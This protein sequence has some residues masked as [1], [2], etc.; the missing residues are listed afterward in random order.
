VVLL[1]P[2]PVSL[3]TDKATATHHPMKRSMT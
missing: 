1:I 2:A 3:N